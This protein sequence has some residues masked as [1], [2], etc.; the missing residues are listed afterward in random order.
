MDKEILNSSG[1]NNA[2]NSRPK[3]HLL[4]LRTLKNVHTGGVMINKIIRNIK[5]MLNVSFLTKDN[6]SNDF[7]KKDNILL[8]DIFHIESL[9]N[10]YIFNKSKYTSKELKNDRQN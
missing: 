8:F 2:N 6:I 9:K 10:I 4:K 7:Y 1:N 3:P 5:K